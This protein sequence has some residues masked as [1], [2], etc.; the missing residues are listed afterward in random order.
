MY[1]KLFIFLFLLGSLINIDG[2]ESDVFQLTD[3]E[4]DSS[5]TQFETALVMFYAP[6]QVF[7]LLFTPTTHL[8]SKSF[9]TSATQGLQIII[10]AAEPLIDIGGLPSLHT[11][12]WHRMV[13][14]YMSKFEINLVHISSSFY[15]ST[16]ADIVKDWSRT[17]KKP[18]PFWRRATLLFI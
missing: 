14:N 3:D 13:F 1:S 10:K 8:T 6:W 11:T 16:G 9:C 2:S 7:S 15:S 12:W 18:L 4:F 17:S 5:I